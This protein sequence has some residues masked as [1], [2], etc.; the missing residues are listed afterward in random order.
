[1]TVLPELLKLDQRND[2]EETHA[3]RNYISHLKREA[4]TAN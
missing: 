4:Q 2:R 1:M 3:F